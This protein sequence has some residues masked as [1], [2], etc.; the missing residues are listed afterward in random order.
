MDPQFVP[1]RL[2]AQVGFVFNNEELLSQTKE[3]LHERKAKKE[4]WKKMI[5][6]AVNVVL[7][8]LAP[9]LK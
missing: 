9:F 7:R 1:L 4:T 2:Y 3:D 5:V 6:L 8:Q